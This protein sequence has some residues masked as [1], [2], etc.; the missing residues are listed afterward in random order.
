MHRLGVDDEAER[1]ELL[2]LLALRGQCMFVGIGN[3]SAAGV[4]GKGL[5]RNACRKVKVSLLNH[6]LDRARD[7]TIRET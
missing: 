5:S 7:L 2:I 1:V 4:L 6:L 3:R